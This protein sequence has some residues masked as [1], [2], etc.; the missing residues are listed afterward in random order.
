ML[1]HSYQLGIART[2]RLALL[3]MI[4]IGVA[5]AAS[6]DAPLHERID[7]MIE[8]GAGGE[9]MATD[10]DD[11]EFLRRVYLDFTG[12]IPPDAVARAF[13]ASGAANKRTALIQELSQSDRFSQRLADLFNVMLMERRGEH[14]QWQAYLLESFKANKP[15]DQLA[16]EI[17][18]PNPR[19]E[20]TRASAYFYT[21]RLE[22]VGQQ[23]T[24]YPGLTRD[25]GRLFLGIDLQCAQCHNHLTVDD[26]KQADFQGL[27][28]FYQNIAI[29]G[30][31]FP[32]IAEKPTV[33]KLAFASVFN[34]KPMTTAP[35]VPTL[36]ADRELAIPSIEK[37]KEFALPADPK[38]K[39]PAMLAF[40][41]LAE[42][43]K[44][45]PTAENGAFARNMVNRLWFVMMGRGLVNP[46]DL[47]HS[48]NP[49]SHPQLLELL[50]KEFTTQKFDVKWLLREL[51]MTRV[52]QRSTIM[53]SQQEPKA[54]RFTVALERRLS[55]EQLLM[56]MLTA[57]GDLDR[58][59]SKKDAKGEGDWPAYE[60][61][62]KRFVGAFAAEPMEPEEHVDHTLKGVLFLRNDA[63]FLSLL[64]PRAGNLMQRLLDEKDAGRL[65]DEL[66]LSVLTRQ[67]TVEETSDVA[68]FVA[69]R[70]EQRQEA[71]RDLVWALMTSAEFAVNH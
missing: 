60:E 15:W 1:L 40:S 69:K 30:A 54:D 11:A 4:T 29:H 68:A 45:L 6:A 23:P 14:P 66:F 41:P 63:M 17:L 65:A 21:R 8:A 43:S 31:A 19:D 35:R 62:R 50:A 47:H 58:V 71:V 25:V 12:S 67:P 64:K 18:N 24:D 38:A 9:P 59:M 13:L 48:G 61:L 3:I 70:G 57:T 39:L 26:Y 32:A 22:K 53:P 16:G 34:K 27:F 56:S 37:G 2:I 5:R 52:Y 44:Q 33:Q 55:S 46:L 51:A 7:A 20:K 49:P 10:S 36:P 28:A 42:L